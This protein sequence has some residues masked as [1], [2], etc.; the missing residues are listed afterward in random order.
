MRATKFVSLII[1]FSLGLS[2][3]GGSNSGGGSANPALSDFQNTWYYCARGGYLVEYA[4]YDNQLVFNDY[5][6]ENFDCTGNLEHYDEVIFSLSF[7]D[8]F[9]DNNNYRVVEVDYLVT[10]STWEAFPVGSSEYNILSIVDGCLFG[11]RYS[12]VYTSESPETRP[13]NLDTKEAFGPEL[14]GSCR[15]F[16]VG[17]DAL[18]D[19]VL[20]DSSADIVSDTLA[21]NGVDFFAFELGAAG[22]MAI[23]SFDSDFD[24]IC[25]ILDETGATLAFGDDT[26]GSFECTLSVA[27][28][29]GKYYVRINGYDDDEFGVYNLDYTF[30]R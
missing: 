23:A 26:G 10:S 18:V 1:L 7:G 17:D 12:D 24:I 27:L 28:S 8:E 5:Q 11:G 21:E 15:L 13:I 6:A 20:N 19:S 22:E 3:C 30:T 9:I 2:A 16:G 29:P 14:N 25:E 4:I